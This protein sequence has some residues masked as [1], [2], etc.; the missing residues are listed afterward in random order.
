MY[1]LSAKMLWH[2][3]IILHDL[4]SKPKGLSESVTWF[5]TRIFQVW[6]QTE[7]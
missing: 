5:L 1:F 6:A 2:I 4:Q 3:R 7:I